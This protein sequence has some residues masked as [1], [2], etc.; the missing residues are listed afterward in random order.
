MVEP[1]GEKLI[2]KQAPKQPKGTYVEIARQFIEQFIQAVKDGT[3]KT[4]MAKIPTNPHTT[5]MDK[6][7]LYNAFKSVKRHDAKLSVDVS[8]IEGDLWLVY[9]EG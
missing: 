6:K 1:F 8:I 4:K 2:F 7:A 5:E 3:C 9:L